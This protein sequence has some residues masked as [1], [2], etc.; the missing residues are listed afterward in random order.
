M[1]L[2]SDVNKNKNGPTRDKTLIV[3]CEDESSKPA[4]SVVRSRVWYLLP[5]IVLG[6]PGGEKKVK[7]YKHI[8]LIKKVK[9]KNSKKKTRA[10]GFF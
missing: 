8:N 9:T 4:A 7:Y 10:G 5:G 2:P 3:V 1:Y 6:F